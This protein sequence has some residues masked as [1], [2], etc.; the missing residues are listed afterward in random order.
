VV[1]TSTAANRPTQGARVVAFRFGTCHG[2]PSY[3]AVTWYFP[4]YGETFDPRRYINACTGN[5]VGFEPRTVR[6]QPVTTVSGERATD[7]DVIGMSCASARR[8]IAVAPAARYLKS[9][10]RW[11]QSGFRC[12]SAGPMG[13]ATIL[14][15]CQLNRR[16]FLYELA[17]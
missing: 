13:F 8:L 4:K 10:G 6:C 16:E 15:D 11:M 9:G 2:R 1:G 3:D 7:V 14:F 5:Y 17:A 12:G